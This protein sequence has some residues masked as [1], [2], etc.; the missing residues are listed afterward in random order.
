MKK[1]FLQAIKDQL[2]SNKKET[3]VP[4]KPVYHGTGLTNFVD[5]Y[6]IIGFTTTGDDPESD[7]I[8]ELYCEEYHNNR[9]TFCFK[10]VLK[11]PENLSEDIYLDAKILSKKIPRAVDVKWAIEY[12]ERYIGD[13]V[14]V[15]PNIRRDVQFLFSYYER[16]L[17]KEFKNNYVDF[18]R[19]AMKVLPHLTKHN[20]CDIVKHFKIKLR[21]VEGISGDCKTYWYCCEALKNTAIENKT[22]KHIKPK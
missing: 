4:P 16:Y 2:L 10:Q 21:N 18:S 17:G 19:L 15:G 20:F 5:D 12:L 22:Y 11:Y 3:A 6:F 9:P 14:V 13:A 8:L 1:P 7:Y